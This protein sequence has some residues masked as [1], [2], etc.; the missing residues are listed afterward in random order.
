RTDRFSGLRP[1]ELQQPGSFRIR[2]RPMDSHQPSL[3]Q[4]WRSRDQPIERAVIRASADEIYGH[5]PLLAADFARN[6]SRVISLFDPSGVQI[7][8]PTILRNVY[9]P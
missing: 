2:G 9:L 6:Q 1:A 7:G 4:L 8:Q 5:V 3:C